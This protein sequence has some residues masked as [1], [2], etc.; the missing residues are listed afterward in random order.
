MSRKPG[1]LVEKDP[2]SIEPY[3]FDWTNWLAEIADSETVA[4]STWSVTPTTTP[5][6][7]I[8]TSSIVTGSLK[9]QA[10]FSGGKPGV[11]YTVT[12]DIVTSSGFKD[13]RSFRFFVKDR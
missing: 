2:E 13:D 3:G 7:S 4:S 9:T 11:Y 8:P 12:N 10:K 1:D 5:A 6:L